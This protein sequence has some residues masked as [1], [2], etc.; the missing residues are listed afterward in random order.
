MQG[1][2]EDEVRIIPLKTDAVMCERTE[3]ER[4]ARFLLKYKSESGILRADSENTRTRGVFHG[5]EAYA[6]ILR[7]IFTLNTHQNG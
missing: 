7:A 6:L 5:P 3:C 2:E 1:Q 4:P